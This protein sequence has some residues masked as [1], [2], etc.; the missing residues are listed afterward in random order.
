MNTL[1]SLEEQHLAGYQRQPLTAE[2]FDIWQDEQVWET[3]VPRQRSRINNIV[4]G[5]SAKIE[6]GKRG[7]M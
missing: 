1:H 4:T 3:A 7:G 2:E 6:C 5:V